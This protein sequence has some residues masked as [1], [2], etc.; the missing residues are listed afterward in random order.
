MGDTPEKPTVFISYSLDDAALKIELIKHLSVLERFKN[1]EIWTPDLIPA[2]ARSDLETGMALNRSSVVLL[3]VSA[4]WLAMLAEDNVLRRGLIRHVKTGRTIIPIILHSCLWREDPLMA[5]LQPIPRDGRP[6]AHYQDKND[7]LHNV[8]EEL[9]ALLKN[10]PLLTN[11]QRRALEPP[12]TPGPVDVPVLHQPDSNRYGIKLS[13]RLGKRKLQF[14]ILFGIL[15]LGLLLVVALVLLIRGEPD[16][17]EPIR[18]HDGALQNLTGPLASY[19]E[20]LYGGLHE[21]D[22]AMVD[23]GQFT[24]PKDA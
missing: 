17:G 5:G 16:S 7:A 20:S 23:G 2:G 11:A 8:V 18:A 24:E 14:S 4:S 12:A 22:A 19:V 1:V 10:T 21:S 9:A 13:L 6:V 3:L 15:N